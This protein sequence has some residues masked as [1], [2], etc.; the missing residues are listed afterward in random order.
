M[1]SHRTTLLT[2]SS[3]P[4]LVPSPSEYFGHPFVVVSS[5]VTASIYGGRYDFTLHSDSLCI[6]P[7]LYFLV[8]TFS[9]GVGRVI[10]QSPDRARASHLSVMPRNNR[11]LQ[12]NRSQ[13]K[14]VQVHHHQIT[15]AGEGT[16]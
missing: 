5:L 8:S 3:E 10:A 15:Q 13:L 6:L 1:T 7:R 9:N 14:Q 12:N 16:E 11:L 2:D 4:K